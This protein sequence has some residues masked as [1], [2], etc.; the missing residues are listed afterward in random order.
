MGEI[1]WNEVD[2]NSITFR[3]EQQPLEDFFKAKDIRFKNEMADDVGF[4]YLFFFL[5]EKKKKKKKKKRRILTYIGI[6]SY[7]S[8]AGQ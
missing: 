4:S 5:Q 7:R 2:S 1:G 3:E 8:G 6:H